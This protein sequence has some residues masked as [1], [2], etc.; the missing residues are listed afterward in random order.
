MNNILFS[1]SSTSS[2]SSSSTSSLPSSL[3]LSLSLS[4]YHYNEHYCYHYFIIIIITTLASEICKKLSSGGFLM[5]YY[6]DRRLDLRIHTNDNVIYHKMLYKP[7]KSTETHIKCYETIHCNGCITMTMH[8]GQGVSNYPCIGG[9][10]HN[11]WN[12]VTR[13]K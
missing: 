8:A 12:L 4:L 5:W 6:D 1:R 10:F 2:S 7:V 3:V 9:L 11:M 13:A